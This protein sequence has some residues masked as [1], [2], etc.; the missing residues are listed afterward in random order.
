MSQFDAPPP[1]K[2]VDCHTHILPPNWE[3]WAQRFGMPLWCVCLS[4]P[5]PALL[6]VSLNQ[7]DGPPCGGDC[8]SCRIRWICQIGAP[9]LWLQSQHVEGIVPSLFHCHICVFCV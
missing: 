1:S 7:V 3:D 9:T 2:R 5:L 8:E 6:S 4:L